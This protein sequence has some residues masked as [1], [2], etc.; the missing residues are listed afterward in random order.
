MSKDNNVQFVADMVV[1]APSPTD[2]TTMLVLLVER[3]L[4]PYKGSMALPG[5][6]VERDEFADQ[7]ARRELREETGVV[8]GDPKFVGLFD[9]PDRDPRGRVVSAA[10]GIWLPA[11]VETTAGD[12]AVHAAWCGVRA[13]LESDDLAFDHREVLATALHSLGFGHLTRR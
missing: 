2:V 5:G 4:A 7:A 6:Y 9:R 10:Y 11:P 13:C 12:D 3:G 1:L 8:V